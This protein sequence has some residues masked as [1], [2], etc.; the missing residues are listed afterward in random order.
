MDSATTPL[1]AREMATFMD[2]AAEARDRVEAR[3][4]RVNNE[5]GTFMAAVIRGRELRKTAENERDETI[6]SDT[7]EVARTL[8]DL[9]RK[10]VWKLS[11]MSRVRVTFEVL[12]A[13]KASP[14]KVEDI[15]SCDLGLEFPVAL[16]VGV[17]HGRKWTWWASL[18]DA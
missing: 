16:S 3:H 17:E 12:E 8:A 2:M 15:I 10:R 9:L 11:S 13:P 4:A 6:A 1:S 18:S 5:V 7:K 14:S